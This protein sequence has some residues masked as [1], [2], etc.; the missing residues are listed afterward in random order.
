MLGLVPSFSFFFFFF[1]SYY[2]FWTTALLVL[3]CRP[4]SKSWLISKWILYLW[5]N[6]RK[7]KSSLSSQALRKYAIPLY[8]NP[9]SSVFLPTPCFRAVRIP[10]TKFSLPME[11]PPSGLEKITW[12]RQI[13]SSVFAWCFYPFKEPMNLQ[14]Y[15]SILWK[16]AFF[17]CSHVTFHLNLNMWNIRIQ[18]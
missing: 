9:L 13:I 5:Y 7:N 2:I 1:E 8:Y 10:R 4:S 3:P 17:F 18:S 6:S 11:L 15:T 14:V 16:I 12:H